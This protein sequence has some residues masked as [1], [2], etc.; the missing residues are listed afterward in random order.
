MAIM[1]VIVILGLVLLVGLIVL[2]A[3]SGSKNQTKKPEDVS[4]VKVIDKKK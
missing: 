3:S 1:G 2:I 4:F